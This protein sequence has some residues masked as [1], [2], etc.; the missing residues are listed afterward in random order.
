MSF[1]HQQNY[2]RVINVWFDDKFKEYFYARE[3]WLRGAPYGDISAQLK[4]K[5]DKKCKSFE[6]FMKN[7][8]YDVYDKFP[9]LP[10]N[11]AWGEVSCSLFYQ[12]MFAS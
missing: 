9:P 10:P 8:A 12:I 4:L 3:P 7:V 5:Q 11:V 1:F 6:W 2:L